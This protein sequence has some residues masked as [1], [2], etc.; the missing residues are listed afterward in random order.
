LI[1]EAFD[2]MSRR[3]ISEVFSLLGGEKETR[4]RIL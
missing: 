3:K 1:I 4:E 2:H